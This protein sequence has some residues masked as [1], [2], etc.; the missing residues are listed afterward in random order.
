MA[1][2]IG[3]GL[4]VV[5]KYESLGIMY[6]GGNEM[7]VAVYARW[8]GADAAFIG[9]FGND[10]AAIH[11]T[12]VLKEVGV[13]LSR[14]R[15]V[16]GENGYATVQLVNGDR[17]F[18]S[19]NNGGVTGLNPI[20]LNNEDL[21]YIKN[22]DVV[23]A[24]INA[25]LFLPEIK[26]LSGSSIPVSYDFSDLYNEEIIRETAPHATFSFLSCGNMSLEKASELLKKVYRLGSRY[27]IGTMGPRGSLLYFGKEVRQDP[28]DVEIV[29]TMGAGDSFIAAFLNAFY[30]YKEKGVEPGE[31]ELQNC[32]LEATKYAT[33]ICTIQGAI[34][35][36]TSIW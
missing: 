7:N 21:Q 17:V 19:T 34:G 24:S 36:E 30:S 35:Y 27:V 31:K 14:C 8:I 18:L 15:Y 6:P 4:N 25:R 29:D 5:D 33:K 23:S 26:K 9:V 11:N 12:N 10:R 32:M 2:I 22:F 16:E 13:D 1:K 3:I 28:I 20:V